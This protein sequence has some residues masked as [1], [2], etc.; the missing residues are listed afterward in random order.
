MVG[1]GYWNLYASV[2]VNWDTL[3]ADSLLAFQKSAERWAALPHYTQRLCAKCHKQMHREI[4]I[5]D[6]RIREAQHHQCDLAC[7]V[8]ECEFWRQFDLGNLFTWFAPESPLASPTLGCG[9]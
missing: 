2:K 9:L 5:L 8:F 3:P 6:R 1:L 7:D 4:M